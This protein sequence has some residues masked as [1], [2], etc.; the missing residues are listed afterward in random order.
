MSLAAVPA[1]PAEPAARPPLR[2]ADADR[3]R[4]AAVLAEAL[5]CGRLDPEEHAERLEACYAARTLAA[6]EPLTAD[7]PAGPADA[8]PAGAPAG[9]TAGATPAPSSEPVHVVLGKLRRGG[10]WPVPPHSVFR[11]SFGAIVLDLRA[12][13]FTRREVVIEA[14]SFCGKVEVLL[15]PEVQVL[16]EGTALLGKRAMPGRPASRPDGPVV[17]FTGRSVLGHLRVVRVGQG[18][19]VLRHLHH[20]LNG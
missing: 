10:Q 12:A 3:D 2:A 18:L 11:A 4:V 15:P 20:L 17:R 9:A 6:L 1:D 19:A 8:A 16:D 13:V 5:A 14:G 7:L